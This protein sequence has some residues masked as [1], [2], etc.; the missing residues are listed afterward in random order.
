MSLLKIHRKVPWRNKTEPALNEKN[1]E[2]YDRELDALDDRIIQLSNT[3]LPSQ[4]AGGFITDFN[5][6]P[7]DGVITI[8]Y[9]SGRIVQ[10][11]TN[12]E[13]IP[14][15][16]RFDEEAQILYIIADDGTE[17]RCNLASLISQYDFQD[18]D[19]ITFFVTDGIVTAQVKR[20]SI[21]A[22][23]LQPNF[24]SDVQTEAARALAGADTAAENALDASGSAKIAQTAAGQATAAE[25]AAERYATTAGAS[26]DVASSS[27][28]RAS[29]SADIA[30]RSETAAKASE[31]TALE[32]KEAAAESARES[33]DSANAALTKAME[34]INSAQAATEQ[35]LLAKS[36]AVGTEGTMRPGDS[37]D[38]SKFFC[39]LA[40]KL[41]ADAQK[42]LD[43][44]TKIV[45]AV[46]VGAIIPAG[47]IT[48]ADLPT[49]PTVG[50][51]YN[52]SDA[53]TTD[54]RFAEGAGILYNAGANVY[55]TKDSQWDVMIGVQLTGVK[56]A[57]ESDYHQGNVTI[58]PASIGLGNVN[59]TADAEKVVKA[60]SQ[61]GNGKNIADTY[62]TKTGDSANNTVH[63]TSADN[64]NLAAW[65]DVP[66]LISGDKHSSILNKISIMFHNVRYLWKL[67]GN[68]QLSI[69]DGTV[70]GAISALNTHVKDI[71]YTF[72][73]I[74]NPYT[75]EQSGTFIKSGGVYIAF[76]GFVL[77][78]EIPPWTS[79]SIGKISGWPYLHMV[80]ICSSVQGGS[81]PYSQ[82][83][84]FSVSTDGIVS[85]TTHGAISNRGWFYGNT[86]I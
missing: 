61:D 27:A 19:M 13:K 38:N 85:L 59:D 29:V 42:L 8:T 31:L 37:T 78:T 6:N 43:Q 57:A 7:A 52:I 2:Q 55:W 17:Q 77:K 71:A 20:G 16:Y 47:T 44:A 75:D 73:A 45:S 34:A 66:P 81:E 51:M 74:D 49:T 39:D 65:E 41:A 22:E 82:S 18:S 64:T 69:G 3:T 76:F 83:L 26:V 46:S 50:F 62:L 33:S 80:G 79:I 36:Y 12:L 15:N 23:M 11:D 58:T 5:V 1:L 67:I 68:T 60:A 24:L 84:L 21:T 14:F 35:A 10:I 25:Q 9:F 28:Q 72:A 4:T 56:G 86:A 40:K 63:F 30:N 32:H 48:F 53:F 54:A 70:T